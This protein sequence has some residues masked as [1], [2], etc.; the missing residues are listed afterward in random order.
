MT[1]EIIVPKKYDMLASI[2]AWIYPDIQPVPEQTTETSFYRLYPFNSEMVP[3]MITQHTSG[4]PLLVDY[5]AQSTSEEEIRE[6]VV[7]TLGLEVD[8]QGALKRI[9][10]DQIINV[11]FNGISGIQPYQS[12]RVFE[13]LIKTIIQQQVSYRAANILTRKLILLL[14]QK[15]LFNDKMLYAFPLSHSI[16]RHGINGLQDLGFG[17]KAKYVHGVAELAETGSLNLEE[18]KEKEHDKVISLLQP[19][20]GIG[21]W[22]IDTLAISGLGNFKVF[23][24]GDLGIRNLLGRLYNDNQRLTT[25]EVESLVSQWGTDQSLVLY[26]LMCADVLGLFGDVGRQQNHKRR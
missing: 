5:F 25:Q 16:V 15:R 4:Q 24:Y 12:P 23:P 9:R 22:T 26:L 19:I 14:S 17:Y 21:L 20:H 2:H 11:I 8:M 3:V 6:C 1:F 13:A 10:N 18:L 7:H